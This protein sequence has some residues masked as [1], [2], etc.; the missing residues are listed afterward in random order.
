MSQQLA[1]LNK[2]LP[3]EA[4]LPP[5]KP[6]GR[7]V[8]YERQLAVRPSTPH[9]ITLQPSSFRNLRLPKRLR[10]IYFLAR[11]RLAQRLIMVLATPAPPCSLEGQDSH[12]LGVPLCLWNG[13]C[14]SGGTH[15]AL[16]AQTWVVSEEI[17]LSVGHQVEDSSLLSDR[18]LLD[19]VL[20]DTA[21]CVA[22][23][24]S[25]VWFSGCCIACKQQKMVAKINRQQQ[26][27]SQGAEGRGE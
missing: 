24:F 9:T 20:W 4:C 1:D 17:S 15:R 8:R 6:V 14:S 25:W 19:L 12:S 16:P 11:T 13:G 22:T 3:P 18:G 5:A 23:I 10:V 7:S 21:T 27:L 26:H 2:R